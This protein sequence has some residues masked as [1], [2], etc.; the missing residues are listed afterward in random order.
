MI[1][2]LSKDFEE[3]NVDILLIIFRNSAIMKTCQEL[4]TNI[5]EFKT[6]FKKDIEDILARTPL[7]I[8]P[9]K[10]KV[11]LDAET[12][13][14]EALPPPLIPLAPASSVQ[15]S[16]AGENSAATVPDMAGKVET[17]SKSQS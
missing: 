15:Q 13:G 12:P 7:I 1:I 16:S 9:R 10:S 3:T 4:E 5:H 6:Q 2:W 17:Q 11:D 14:T 8:K